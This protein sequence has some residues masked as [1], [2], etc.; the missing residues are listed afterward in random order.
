MRSLAV[1]LL[2]AGCTPSSGAKDSLEIVTG[3]AT[4]ADRLPVIVALHGYGGAPEEITHLFDTFSGK[5]RVIA[6]RGTERAHAGWGWFPADRASYEIPDRVA[7][8]ADRVIAAI[9]T[10]PAGCGKPIVIGFSQGGMLS[11]A[12]AARAPERIAAAIP[13]AGL[14]PSPLWPKKTASPPPVFVYHGDADPVVPLDEDE[15]TREAFVAAGYA[16]TFKKMP[17][18]RHR[19]TPEMISDVYAVLEKLLRDEG[20]WVN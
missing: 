20:C 13:L 6:P 10:A 17:N 5:A 4:K 19:V 8:A 9:A 7:A 11:W 15:M 14:L 2:L 12:V 1:L 3:G 16:V 18:V